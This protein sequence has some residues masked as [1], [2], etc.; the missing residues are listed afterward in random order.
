MPP[1]FSVCVSFTRV[2]LLQKFHRHHVIATQHQQLFLFA[3]HV[4]P[5]STVITLA[6]TQSTTPLHREAVRD[7]GEEG[8]KK[9]TF[10]FILP[11]IFLLSSFFILFSFLHLRSRVRHPPSLLVYVRVSVCFATENNSS[12]PHDSAQQENNPGALYT[13]RGQY[14]R[15]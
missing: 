7:R 3:P 4:F 12:A 14:I 13:P 8:K 2:F 5:S 1:W 15:R 10:F 6:G 9:G 11:S